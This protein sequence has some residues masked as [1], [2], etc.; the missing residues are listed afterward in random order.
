M[1]FFS[2]W[3]QFKQQRQSLA[4][5]ENELEKQTFRLALLIEIIRSLNSAESK[6]DVLHQVIQAAQAVC[7]ATGVAIALLNK[8]STRLS[9]V[10]SRGFE[11]FKE[12]KVIF[13]NKFQ[14]TLAWRAVLKGEVMTADS[15][16]EISILHTQCAVPLF[17]HQHVLG[18]LLIYQAK[19]L[20]EDTIDFLDVLSSQATTAFINVSNYTKIQAK[21][22]DLGEKA[23]TDPMTKMFNRLYMAERCPEEMSHCKR[24]GHPLSL[25]M[26]DVDHF[27][28]F[29][30]Q[31]GHLFGDIVLKEVSKLAKKSIRQHDIPIRYGG[32]EFIIVLPDSSVDMS[33]I[34]A[35][36]LRAGVEGYE[37]IDP[38]KKIKAK[39]TISI[40]VAE[41]DRK[42]ELNVLI[43]QADRALY[44]AK[45][46]GRNRVVRYK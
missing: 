3:K 26:F 37:F 7:Q 44:Q 29:N 17:N 38:E 35:E 46:G 45:E 9:L 4:D 5:A 36:R 10:A 18:V 12:E 20:E 33:M 31:Y 22:L 1:F 30:D 25:V 34:A 24:N 6:E 14:D 32:E 15:L 43:D 2:L 8:D 40:G 19:E 16:V 41:W 11:N 13:E 23:H 21:A 27:K 42:S 39:V 28:K